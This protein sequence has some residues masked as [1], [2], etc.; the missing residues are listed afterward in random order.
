MMSAPP[1]EAANPAS[2]GTDPTAFIFFIYLF[3]IIALMIYKGVSLTP[4]RLF[5]IFLLGIIATGRIKV[6]LK[7]WIPFIGLI[8]AYE[9]LRGFAD[10]IGFTVHFDSLINWEKSLFGSLP[11]LE[12]QKRF[13]STDKVAWYDVFFSVVYFLHFV[14]PLLIALVFWFKSRNLYKKFVTALLFISFSGFVLYVLYPTAPPW[15][16]SNQGYIKP[17]H[18]VIN[19]T[20]QKTNS[21]HSISYFYQRLNPN[22]VAAFP[23]LHAAYAALGFLAL[24]NFSAV[25][26]LAFLPLAISIWVGIV[27]L[28]EHY[29][30][31]ALAGFV[32]AYV[33]F[34]LV[35]KFNSLKKIYLEL[36]DFSK[37]S[38][39]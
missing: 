31:D 16:A 21:P 35:Y 33:C 27:Y 17:V 2:K 26:G 14:Y 24:F 30:V 4:D 36:R 19:D 32:L 9:V 6:F 12:L 34:I 37:K 39:Q 13:Y 20:L 15:L 22:P 18:K 28:G 8:L 5:L 7:D 29:I 3:A 25:F 10:G 23:S 38:N 11:P 1:R